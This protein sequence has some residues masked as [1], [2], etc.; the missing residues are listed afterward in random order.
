MKK[1]LVIVNPISGKQKLKNELLELVAFL[2]KS[3]YAPTVMT[4][5][6]KGHAT[7]LA[8]EH[9]DG[10]DLVICCGGD[11]TLGEV[12]SGV[13]G[14]KSTTP[15]GYIP[16]G[17]TNDFANSLKIPS[18][19]L[20]AAKRAVTGYPTK[21]DIGRFGTSYFTYVASFGA[22][23]SSSYSTPQPNKNAIGHLAY[24]LEGAKDL[25]SLRPYHLKVSANGRV[26]ENDYIFGAVSNSLVVG[27]LIRM[28]NATVKFSDG[29]FEVMLIKFPSGL[30]SLSKIVASLQSQKYDPEVIDFFQAEKLTVECEEKF[31]WSLDGEYNPGNEKIDISVQ[32]KAISL[33][34]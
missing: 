3:G 27:G 17:T 6:R 16:S 31:P 15:L 21:L 1:V 14:K 22:F 23:T 12:I 7:A 5:E 29:L 11:G 26:Y 33:N 34:L 20:E 28:N 30:D 24:V 19:T 4:T 13:I 8:R 2:C 25:S 10:Y 18:Q 9:A 32:K